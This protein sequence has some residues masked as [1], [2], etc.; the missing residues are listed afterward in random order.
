MIRY[1]DVR[2]ISD[3]ENARLREQGIRSMPA[4]VYHTPNGAERRVEYGW[5]SKAQLRQMFSHE[6]VAEEATARE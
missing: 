4:M 2:A 1:V 6:H 5:K 3:G